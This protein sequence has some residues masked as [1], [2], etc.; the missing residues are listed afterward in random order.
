M[1]KVIARKSDESVAIWMLGGLYEIIAAGDETGGAVTIMR[2]TLPAG[3]GAP[4]HTHPGNE[5][6]YVLD[7]EVDVHIGD[8]VVTAKPGATFFFPA[9]TKE[10]FEATTQATV[11][12]T[13]APGGIDKFFNE[14]GEPAAS[15]SIPPPSDVPPDFERIVR[16]GAEYGMVI[17]GPPA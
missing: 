13:Y 15:R 17:E 14:V 5:S 11:L 10:W 1:T 16:V 12:V 6:L 7:G 9:G 3:A 2:M 4:P 8:D